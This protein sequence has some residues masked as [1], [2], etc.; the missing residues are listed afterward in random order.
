LWPR[1][2]NGPAYKE[3]K[4]KETRKPT[5]A[6]GAKSPQGS[7]AKPRRQ[8]SAE[9]DN[10]RND[11]A[12]V[13]L[14]RDPAEGWTFLMDLPADA[15]AE[16]REHYRRG[17][18]NELAILELRSRYSEVPSNNGHNRQGPNHC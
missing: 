10:A 7:P 8:T 3:L 18:L 2:Q 9:T 16:I 4:N 6:A 1:G 11:A 15:L 13:A 12:I 14:F 5:E 17:E